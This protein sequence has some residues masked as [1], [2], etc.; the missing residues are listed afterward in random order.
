SSSS[1]V[2]LALRGR[3]KRLQRRLDHRR[4]PPAAR[5]L[6]GR[7]GLRISLFQTGTGTDYGVL[8]NDVRQSADERDR[9]ILPRQLA[10]IVAELLRRAHCP[11]TVA[12]CTSALR[13]TVAMSITRIP[14]PVPKA[15]GSGGR[16]SGVA[17]LARMARCS[18]S[19]C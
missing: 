19:K 18:T 16:T 9:A 6:L 15:G 3:S 13:W 11:G 7:D 1:S 5:A 17:N 12:G 4:I 14:S 8:L 10:Q 2:P